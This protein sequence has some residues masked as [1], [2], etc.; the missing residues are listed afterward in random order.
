[1]LAALLSIGVAGYFLS[2]LLSPVA[3]VTIAPDL[4]CDLHRASC[5]ATL[6]DG[7]RLE[8]SLAPR[9]IPVSVPIEASV[10]VAGQAVD[11]VEL[12]FAG[13]TMNMGYNRAELR[14]TGPATFV[15]TATLPACVTGRMA[16]QAT[17]LVE[18]GRT[19]IAV[20][21]RFDAGA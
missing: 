4:G 13:V 2:P 10:H 19:R 18:R 20:P 6:P 5:A 14:P 3:D 7:G 9:P 15:G 16:W 8:L 12:D 21:F 17:V 11:R 1:M